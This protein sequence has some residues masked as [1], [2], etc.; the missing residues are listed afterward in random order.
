M[1]PISLSALLLL[2]VIT[3]C[4]VAESA[5]QIRILERTA[6]DADQSLSQSNYKEKRLPLTLVRFRNGAWSLSLVRDVTRRA[7]MILQRCGI[8][9]AP[10]EMVLVEAPEKYQ[11]LDTYLSRVLAQTLSLRKPTAYFVTDTKQEPAFDAEA[12]G[13]ANSGT[14]P[15]MAD[16]VWITRPVRDAPI[17]LAHELV[18]VLTDSGSHTDVPGNLMN[19]ETSP[20]NTQLTVAQCNEMRAVGTRNGLLHA[21]P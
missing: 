16:S 20:A 14:R 4:S 7:V 13:R 17:A 8:V 10:V 11:Y 15:E 5:N 3:I 9:A 12:V 19:D 1:R 2:T 21:P 18:H 6:V